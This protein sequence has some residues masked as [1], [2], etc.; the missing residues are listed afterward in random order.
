MDFI[1][2]NFKSFLPLMLSKA[3]CE[4]PIVNIKNKQSITKLLFLKKEKA[5]IIIEKLKK[6][7][8]C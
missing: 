2:K 3:P 8:N 6:I 4:I 7:K 1:L 5:E